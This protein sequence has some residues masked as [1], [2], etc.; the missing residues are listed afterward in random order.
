MEGE[1]EKDVLFVWVWYIQRFHRS[2]IQEKD[3]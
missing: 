2:I 3:I 1:D